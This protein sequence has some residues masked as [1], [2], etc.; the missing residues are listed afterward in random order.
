ML[1]T[2]RARNLSCYGYHRQTTPFLTDF[3]SDNTLFENAFSPA[4][5]TPTSH[6]S[7][8]TGT[9]PWVHQTGR[10][11][12]KLHPQLETL[13]EVLQ[14]DGYETVGFSS[15][16]Y[17]SPV[18]EFDRGF[19]TF[20]FNSSAFGEPF[21]DGVPIQQM[22]QSIDSA[23][24]PGEAWQALKYI[25]NNDG[26]LVQTFGN[27]IVKKL[28]K[29]GVFSQADSGAQ[30]AN[31]FVRDWLRRRDD[32]QPFFLFINYMEGHT[33]YQAPD[34]YLADFGDPSDDR[35]WES[36]DRFFA[37]TDGDLDPT[38]SRLQDLYD[39]SISYLDAQLRELTE[40]IDEYA[41]DETLIIITGDHGE[42]F[43]E[44][45]IYG[46]TAGLYNEITRVP[47]LIRDPARKKETSSEPVSIQWIMPTLLERI[48]LS[49]PEYCVDASLFESSNP[50]VVGDTK[51]LDL[52]V[53][54]P[55]SI[56]HLTQPAR[57][58]V[59]DEWKLIS[60]V[61]SDYSELYM[62]SDEEET[63]DC[64]SRYPDRVSEYRNRLSAE[65]ERF[66]DLSESYS[67]Q[68]SIDSETSQQLKEL[69]YVE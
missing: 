35:G 61:D 19:D 1:D 39:G 68:V 52:S 49:L 6:A 24:F 7:I 54:I 41:D 50:P 10:K 69:G 17:I 47:L 65:I 33:P 64:F 27:W 25:R 4:E 57:F 58:C 67:G 12:S 2:V 45:D 66:P 20:L 53:D 13:A 22:R 18:F 51:A 44:H 32:D 36:L 23:T 56:G 48:G 63:E 9:Y 62:I 3:A 30:K 55:D 28:N 31:S 59:D 43:G 46:H 14:S 15:N 40:S 26:S 38:A 21:S 34:Q 5:W 16:T 37:D 60:G 42:A 8:F 11:S 29:R